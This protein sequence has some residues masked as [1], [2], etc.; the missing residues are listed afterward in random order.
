MGAG[1]TLIVEYDMSGGQGTNL[2]SWF[3]IAFGL[4]TSLPPNFY[5]TLKTD[6]AGIVRT[7]YP[8]GA[9]PEYMQAAIYLDEVG[10]GFG[11]GPSYTSDAHV[12]YTLNL[13]SAGILAN[14]SATAIF[15][16]DDGR[17]GS[18]D[19]TASG[20]FTWDSSQNYIYLLSK[21]EPHT[22]AN[23]FIYSVPEPSTVILLAI[24]GF[25]L[26]RRRFR[27]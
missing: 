17:N 19:W 4:G 26:I 10:S 16:I 12:R 9:G 13:S 15:E 3:G 11:P 8:S 7:G 21:S 25:C 18:Y 24:G 5:D 6:T 1:R 22:V 23:L 14:E 2:D 27:P 20:S